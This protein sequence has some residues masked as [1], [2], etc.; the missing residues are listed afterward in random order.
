[1]TVN[2]IKLCVGINDVDHLAKLQS[3]RFQKQK[4]MGIKPELRHITRNH[5]RRSAEVL[6]GGSLYWVIKGFIRVRQPILGFDDAVNDQ[7]KPACA[8]ILSNLL[9]KTQLRKFRAFQGWRYF[10]CED[11]P[12]DINDHN[13]EADIPDTMA[14]ELKNLG[15][16]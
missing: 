10:K 9:I 8:I 7:G 1:M 6:D 15:L 16:L 14:E 2:I 11:A 4:S 3:E 5:P 12:D 13:G